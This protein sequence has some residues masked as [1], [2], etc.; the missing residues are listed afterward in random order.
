MDERLVLLKGRLSFKQ[1]ISS[2]KARFGIKWYQLCTQNG[3]PFDFLVYH[4]NL[5]PGLIIMEDGSLITENSCNTDAEVPTQGTP[6][7]H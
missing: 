2:K 1:Y 3:I 5:A 6:S 7:I 4:G